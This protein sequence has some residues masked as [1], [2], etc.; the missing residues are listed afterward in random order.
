[1]LRASDT[2]KYVRARA[3]RSGDF[4]VVPSRVGDFFRQRKLLKTPMLGSADC[5]CPIPPI[6]IREA[7]TTGFTDAQSVQCK[8]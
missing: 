1:M 3:V 5:N 7:K 2:D 4:N 8:Q 6:N